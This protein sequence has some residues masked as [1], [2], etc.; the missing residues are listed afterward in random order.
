MS[1]AK[2]PIKEMNFETA[3]SELENIVRS[4]ESGQTTLEDSI[5]AYERG[6][7]LKLHCEKK[8]KDAQ[9]KIEKITLASDG[10]PKTEAIEN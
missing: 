10:T 4:L 2:K 7:E 9:L 3:L 1:D 8:L 5:N 6:T